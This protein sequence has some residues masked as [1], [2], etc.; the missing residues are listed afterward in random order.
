MYLTK[1]KRGKALTNDQHYIHISLVA[2]G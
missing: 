2:S 1:K